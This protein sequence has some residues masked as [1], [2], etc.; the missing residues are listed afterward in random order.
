[1]RRSAEARRGVLRRERAAG[2]RAGMLCAGR[3]GQ[4]AGGAGGGGAG[5]VG[6]VGASL[7]VMSAYRFVRHAAKLAI[8][9]VIVNNGPTRGDAQAQLIIDAPLGRTLAA[10]VERCQLIHYGS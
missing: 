8:P 10:V 5:A 7:P 6:V 1:M 9:V 3:A 4:R 2:S